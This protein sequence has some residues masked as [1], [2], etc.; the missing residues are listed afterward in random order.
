VRRVDCRRSP[1]ADHSA[2][3]AAAAASGTAE[4]VNG[5]IA[6]TPVLQKPVIR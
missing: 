5:S 3:K 6:L 4:N 2:I 1:H